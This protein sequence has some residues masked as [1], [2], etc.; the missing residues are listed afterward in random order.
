MRHA[1]QLKTRIMAQPGP[2]TGQESKLSQAMQKS[3]HQNPAHPNTGAPHTPYVSPMR[4]WNMNF[5]RDSNPLTER[6]TMEQQ[7]LE[8][9]SRITSS[10]YIWLEEMISTP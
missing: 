10:T 6:R 9:G 7:T 3:H 1:T 8:F 4:S 2:F 5:Q